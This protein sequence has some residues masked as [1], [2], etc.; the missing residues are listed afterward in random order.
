MLSQYGYWVIGTTIG[1]N[2]LVIDEHKE[3]LYYA[4]HTGWYDKSLTRPLHKDF[5]PIP[6]SKDAVTSAII[7]LFELPI[8]NPVGR[9]ITIKEILEGLD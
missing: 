8:S 1:G 9:L 5:N 7:P 2:A 4:D 3:N 6:Y